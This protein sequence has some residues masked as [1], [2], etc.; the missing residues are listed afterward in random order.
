MKPVI[1]PANEVL[2]AAGKTC[3]CDRQPGLHSAPL[4]RLGATSFRVGFFP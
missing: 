3:R 4:L 1:D 2:K